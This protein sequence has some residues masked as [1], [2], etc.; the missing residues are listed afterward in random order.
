MVNIELNSLWIRFFQTF[1]F[2]KF[3]GIMKTHGKINYMFCKVKNNYIFLTSG[4]KHWDGNLMCC[5]NSVVNQNFEA[6]WILALQGELESLLILVMEKWFIFNTV[7]LKHA[8]IVYSFNITRIVSK[9]LSSMN[10][11]EKFNQTHTQKIKM[12]SLPYSPFSRPK[13]LQHRDSPSKQRLPGGKFPRIPHLLWPGQCER[14]HSHLLLLPP[15]VSLLPTLRGKLR[16]AV[17]AFSVPLPFPSI[18]I[19]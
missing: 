11:S 16:D 10:K 7:C 12:N 6:F 15:V 17:E 9:T 2:S 13:T 14:A 19:K 3:I 8:K 5:F 4:P 18:K 1:F